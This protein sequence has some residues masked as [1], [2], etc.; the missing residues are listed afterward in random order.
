[1]RERIVQTIRT[2]AVVRAKRI[3]RSA[4]VLRA[5][6][7]ESSLALLELSH[8]KIHDDSGHLV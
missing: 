5:K 2:C 7:V 4:S 8:P 3:R 6:E 1:V